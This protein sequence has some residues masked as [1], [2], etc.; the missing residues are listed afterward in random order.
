MSQTKQAATTIVRPTRRQAIQRCWNEPNDGSS[1]PPRS[2]GRPQPLPLPDAVWINPPKPLHT[3][4][5]PTALSDKVD[6][7]GII[8]CGQFSPDRS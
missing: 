5:Q 2:Y 7:S 6:S 1:A 4:E 8:T 3:A